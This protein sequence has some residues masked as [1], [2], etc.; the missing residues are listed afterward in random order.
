HPR[1]TPG[2]SA[3]I[4]SAPSAGG[5]RHGN[6]QMCQTHSWAWDL[7]GISTLLLF[8]A[9][10]FRGLCPEAAQ[11]LIVWSVSLPPLDGQVVLCTGHRFAVQ[12]PVGHG[13][14]EEVET[15]APLAKG[16]G[17]LQGFGRG[18]PVPRPVVCGAEGVPVI[19]LVR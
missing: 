4:I 14:E 19:A 3:L 18:F 15:I 5:L 17:F 13:Q 2:I 1:G 8:D 6:P 10:E 16:Y 11:L 7:K 12:F 9:Q